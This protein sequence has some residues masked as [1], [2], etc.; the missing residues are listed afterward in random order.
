MKF[1]T[2]TP[3][4]D[5]SSTWIAYADF[6]TTVLILFVIIAFVALAKANTD[7]EVDTTLSGKV[8]DE[9]TQQSLAGVE[10]TLGDIRT[11]TDREGKFRF[12]KID[13]KGGLF[14]RLQAS[15]K[16]YLPYNDTIGLVQGN[17]S[18]QISLQKP[19]ENGSVS[20][21][22][23]P[24]DAYFDRSRAEIKREKIDELIEQGHKF[25]DGLKPGEVIVVMGFTDDLPYHTDTKSNWELSGE[26][27]AAV[28]RVFQEEKYGVIIP[29]NRLIAM[30][31]GEFNPLEAIKPGDSPD[32]R[33]TKRAKNRRIE[34]RKMKGA[35]V[36]SSR[37]AGQ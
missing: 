5:E 14:K 4:Q 25:R 3:W 21:I 6:L 27:A 12:E 22:T 31:F 37:Q 15:F 30:G 2:K 11:V 1:K 26:R 7:A 23:L 19:R 32:A 33:E 13:I 35:E 8:L 20:V 24:G 29:G 18:R 10:V 34:I 28:C 9:S 16:D 36:F 17:N